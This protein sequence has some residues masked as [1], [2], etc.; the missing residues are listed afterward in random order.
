MEIRAATA[1]VLILPPLRAAIRVLVMR[2][3]LTKPG[4]VMILTDVVEILAEAMARAWTQLLLA[5]D[6]PAPARRAILMITAPAR[7]RM[8]AIVTAQVVRVPATQVVHAPTSLPRALATHALAQRAI[9]RQGRPVCRDARRAL[10]RRA[11]SLRPVAPSKALTAL[12]R[13]RPAI[14]VVPRRSLAR[15]RVGLAL[16]AALL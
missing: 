9:A 3:I 6:T 4:H 5:L 10:R 8:A 13:A 2:A 14:Q 12:R 7:I 1:L 11:M 15:M 16:P